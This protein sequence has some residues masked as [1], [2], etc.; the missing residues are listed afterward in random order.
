MF[1]RPNA[2]WLNRQGHETAE[3]GFERDRAHSYI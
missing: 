2:S 1:P 3:E